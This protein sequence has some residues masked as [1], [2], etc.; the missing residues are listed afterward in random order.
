MGSTVKIQSVWMLTVVVCYMREGVLS[1]L[2]NT[3]IQATPIK[4][5]LSDKFAAVSGAV[6]TPQKI[7]RMDSLRLLVRVC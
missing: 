4:R 1:N 2:L 7:E 6:A 5:V 3:A